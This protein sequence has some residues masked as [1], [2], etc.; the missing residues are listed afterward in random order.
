MSENN[1]ILKEILSLI[2]SLSLYRAVEKVMLSHNQE[3]PAGLSIL[4]M[5]SWNRVYHKQRKT[6]LPSKTSRFWSLLQVSVSLNTPED[7][8]LWALLGDSSSAPPVG[9]GDHTRQCPTF[10]AAT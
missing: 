3:P 4:S 1:E 10:R 2:N 5:S 8:S 9:P 6:H 7:P